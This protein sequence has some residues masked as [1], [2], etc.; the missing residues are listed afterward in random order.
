MTHFGQTPSQLLSKEHPKRLPRQECV[1]PLCYNATSVGNIQVFMPA[2]S[3]KQAG[4]HQFGAVIAMQCTGDRLVVVHE[5]LQV[6]YYRWTAAF[7]EGYP[8]SLRPDK[9]R[10]LPSASL[11]YCETLLKKSLAMEG[12]T[13]ATA[14][15]GGGG[16]GGGAAAE[17]GHGDAA[18][19][20]SQTT[21]TVKSPVP[22]QPHSSSLATRSDE[23]DRDATAVAAPSSPEA[24]SPAASSSVSSSVSSLS[25]PPPSSSSARPTSLL[26][27]L[28]SFRFGNGAAAAAAGNV[29]T[30]VT[31]AD[32]GTSASD[33]TAASSTA[34]ADETATSPPPPPPST[35]DTAA[36]AASKNL[37]R[38]GS[39]YGA[40]IA[41]GQSISSTIRGT[42]STSA[43]ASAAAGASNDSSNTNNSISSSSGGGGGGSALS[44]SLPRVSSRYFGK[45]VQPPPGTAANG[46]LGLASVHG[47][48]HRHGHAMHASHAAIHRDGSVSAG[49]WTPLLALTHHQVAMAPFGQRMLTCGYWDHAVKLHAIDT[50]KEVSSVAGSHRGVITTLE[51]GADGQILISGGMDGCLRVWV[52]EKPSLA[53]ALTP[54]PFYS[55][56]S[57]LWDAASIG[58][59]GSGGTLGATAVG[60]GSVSGVNGNGSAVV[61]T[62]ASSLAQANAPLIC[63]HAMPGHS[64][65][66]TS[67]SYSADLDMVLS[68]DSEGLLCVHTVRQGQFVRAMKH[69]V[70]SNIDVVLAMTPGYLIAHSASTLTLSVTW[71]NGQVLQQITVDDRIECMVCNKASLA[72]MASPIF[73]CGTQR[74]HIVF[75]EAATL[76]E[77]HRLTALE[78]GGGIRSLSFSDDEQFLL[79][80]C[81]DGSYAIATDAEARKRLQLLALQK[82]TLGG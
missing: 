76:K 58:G 51:V 65:P 32:A 81:R 2:G 35:D 20:P 3:Q 68:G 37:R 26:G 24:P 40:A 14:G 56:Y 60:G 64:S 48:A 49:T 50:M 11:A 12:G 27:R 53:Q 7:E 19:R 21:A 29:A 41:A 77:L 80:G 72:A 33:D 9:H 69:M 17:G 52:V 55:D 44:S 57:S 42:S 78:H 67:V 5:T 10:T 31:S 38:T 79:I 43:S 39:L 22:S 71:V 54:E 36:A 70:G 34:V 62:T 28:S 6:C 61:A 59:N 75:R 15:G 45:V 1:L 13:A 4:R 47:G 82:T 25:P 30:V 18:R 74:G 63:L 46:A 16:G 73:V 66:I 8:F 23:Y